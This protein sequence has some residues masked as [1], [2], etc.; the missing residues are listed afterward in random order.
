[1]EVTNMEGDA[2]KVSEIG[3]SRRQSKKDLKSIIFLKELELERHIT[4]GQPHFLA[5]LFEV[6]LTPFFWVVFLLPP[7]TFFAPALFLID[8]F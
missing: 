5:D 6:F 7:A 3:E 4:W 8:D 2:R 1:M